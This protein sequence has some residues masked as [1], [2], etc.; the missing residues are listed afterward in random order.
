MNGK[1]SPGGRGGP[2]DT[3]LDRPVAIGESGG[4]LDRDLVQAHCAGGE[5]SAINGRWC[6][7]DTDR[8]SRRRWIAS[9]AGDSD[10]ARRR[11]KGGSES[12]APKNEYFTGFGGHR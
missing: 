5:G 7:V 8:R 1:Y 12:C 11:G 2:T 6:V 3:G 10:A 9:G 4:D